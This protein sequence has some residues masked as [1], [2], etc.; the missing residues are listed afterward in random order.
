LGPRQKIA[1]FLGRVICDASENRYQIGF[2]VEAV[3]LGGLDQRQ[4]ASSA[5]TA[6]VRRG[7]MMPGVWAARLLSPIRSIRFLGSLPLLSPIKCMAAL[8]I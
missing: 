8:V 4:D 6:L 1:D 2:G 5:F 7:V 3:E